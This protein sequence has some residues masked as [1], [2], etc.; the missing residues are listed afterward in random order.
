M[1]MTLRAVAAVLA[2]TSLHDDRSALFTVL[3]VGLGAA[4][5]VIVG[6]LPALVAAVLLGYLP[7]P[8]LRRWDAS[9]VLLEP[10]LIE[11]AAEPE[12]A[13]TAAPASVVLAAAEEPSG[14]PS[15]RSRPLAILAHARHQAVYDAAYAEQLDRVETLRSAIG[16]RRSKAPEPPAD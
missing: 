6:V 4:V 3:L 9:G 15:P 2:Q 11:F 5:G 7:P 8:R 12:R 13:P 10:R 16:G 14:D 1:L